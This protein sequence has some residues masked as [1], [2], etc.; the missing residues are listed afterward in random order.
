MRAGKSRLV[1][2]YFRVVEKVARDLSFSQSQ[3]VAMQPK[4]LR[5]YFRHS[6]KTALMVGLLFKVKVARPDQTRPGQTRPDQARPGQARPGQTRPG[7]ARPDQARPDQTRPGQTRPD[8]T[9]PG[10]T[11]PGQ[12]RPGQTRPGQAR[13]DQTRPGQARPDP[14]QCLELVY[15]CGGRE[16]GSLLLSGIVQN[17]ICLTRHAIFEG[18]VA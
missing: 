3:S 5:N 6:I 15:S 18:F 14:Y 7:Q 11:R 4:Q 2:F 13:P 12:A 17:S 8:Q 10:Q 16:V 1:W 9:R